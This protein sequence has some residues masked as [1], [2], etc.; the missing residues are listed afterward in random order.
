MAIYNK[1]GGNLTVAFN[2]AGDQ[3]TRAFDISGNMVF[4]E[5]FNE[6]L[7]VPSGDLNASEVIPLPDLYEAGKGFTCTGLASDGTHYYIGD[8][9]TL[10]GTSYHSQ[11]VVTDDFVNVVRTIPL[12]SIQ[13]FS[14]IQG[15]AFDSSDDTLWCCDASGGKVYHITLQGAVISSF[16]TSSPTGIAYSAVD[17]TLWLLNYSNK[18]IHMTK[19]GVTIASYNFAY[20]ETLDQCFLDNGRGYL[21][22]TAGVNYSGR[23]N[24]Y[25]FNT[26][27]GT[28]SIACTVDSYSVEGIAIEPD[29]MIILNDGLY[30]EATV[31]VNQANIYDLGSN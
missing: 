8:I 31:R 26:A 28:Q 15:V 11:I 23:N 14:I 6:S 20:S 2:Y 18:I 25:L 21:Y 13:G 4:N 5:V 9:G 16:S 17:D 30:H 24:V 7:P 12:Y 22:I 29:R 10:S 19:A 1:T 3:I 27:T